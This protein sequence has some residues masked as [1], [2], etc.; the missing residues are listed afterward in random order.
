MEPDDANLVDLKLITTCRGM[1]IPIMYAAFCLEED[2]SPVDV[3]TRVYG[4]ILQNGNLE[5]CKPLIKYLQYQLH[6]SGD[7][8]TAISDEVNNLRQPW[9]TPEFL[10]HRNTIM[11]DMSVSRMNAETAPA[12]QAAGG[13]S[14]GISAADMQAI[15]EAL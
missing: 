3:W 2:L 9:V 12:A 14:G 11:G 4:L 10:M 6:G 5:I 8:N 13:T 7:A 15:I 1:W